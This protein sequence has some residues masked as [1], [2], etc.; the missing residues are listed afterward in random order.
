MVRYE[1]KLERLALRN[2]G[3]PIQKLNELGSK[4]FKA[5]QAVHQSNDLVV[6]FMKEIETKSAPAKKKEAPKKQA[7]KKGQQDIKDVAPTTK[8]ETEVIDELKAEE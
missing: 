6:L 7:S 4:G 2:T 3:R 8:Q 5:V 1:Y